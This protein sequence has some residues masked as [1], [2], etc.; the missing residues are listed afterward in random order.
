MLEVAVGKTDEQDELMN[1]V[2]M[3]AKNNM[4][5]DQNHALFC[6]QLTSAWKNN[7]KRMHCLFREL[8][9]SIKEK[10]KGFKTN[11][12]AARDFELQGFYLQICTLIKFLEAG[13]LQMLMQRCL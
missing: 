6:N 1:T 5:D 9:I 10:N 3:S 12:V 13:L 2:L 4:K 8:C 11:K 7:F